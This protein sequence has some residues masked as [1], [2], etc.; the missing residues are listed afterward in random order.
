MPLRASTL[1]QIGE[2]LESSSTFFTVH[3][4]EI[5]QVDDESSRRVTL[6]ISYRLEPE[7][8]FRARIPDETSTRQREVRNIADQFAGTFI[9]RTETYY[10]ITCIV[11]PGELT[12]GGPVSCTGLRSLLGEIKDWLGRIEADIRA[13]PELRH[14]EEQ[15][16]RVEELEARFEHLI[17][18][19]ADEYFTRAE[20]EILIEKI[21]SLHA[22]LEELAKSPDKNVRADARRFQEDL[23]ALRGQ[24]ALK[25]RA[26]VHALSARAAGW[27]YNHAAKALEGGAESVVKAL[28]DQSDK[29]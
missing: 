4:F 26:W 10:D 3:D 29:M 20:A 8:F 27:F 12:D 18:S 25:K 22:K 11:S 5:S 21:E 9:D 17:N 19:S 28:T 7:F 13:T 23:E 16:R 14:V 6:L 24:L 1:R 15:R 2:T